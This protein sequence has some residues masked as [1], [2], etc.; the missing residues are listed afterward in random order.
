MAWP[1]RLSSHGMIIGFFGEPARP[2]V[3]AIGMPMSMCVA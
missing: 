2:I 3:E 1:L